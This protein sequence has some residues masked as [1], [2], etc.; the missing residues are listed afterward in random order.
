MLKVALLFDKNN[1]WIEKFF[2]KKIEDLKFK[3]FHFKKFYSYKK[4]K[5]FDIVFILNF[6][7]IIKKEY[8]KKNKLNLVIHA[9]NLPIG[10]GFAPM[11]WQ[12]LK[13]I[14]IITF[15]LIEAVEKVD[16]GNIYL[17]KKLRLNGN[18]LYDELRTKQSK[19][20]KEIM[21]SFLRKYPNISSQKQKG[22]STY[23][24]KRTELDSE[25]DINKPIKKLFPLM[26]IA[27]NN[28][29]PLFFKFNGKKF[30]LKIYDKKF[31]EKD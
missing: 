15:S 17:T 27:N 31:D 24:R 14:N 29:W 6:T 16:S 28:L 1:N 21:M 4:I 26:R 25:L 5:K 12:I 7:H 13:G 8:L 22:K 30:Y 2:P 3:K 11:Q 20:I 18:E 9:S 23:F 19:A 10:K